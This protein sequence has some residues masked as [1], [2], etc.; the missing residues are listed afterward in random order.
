VEDLSTKTVMDNTE[1]TIFEKLQ[2]KEN[3]DKYAAGL[4]S[5]NLRI[6]AG[7]IGK[8]VSPEL[9]EEIDEVSKDVS[10][11]IWA[12]DRG[13]GPVYDRKITF[14]GIKMVLFAAYNYANLSNPSSSRFSYPFFGDFLREI[15]GRDEIEEAIIKLCFNKP[16]IPN[17]DVKSFSLELIGFDLSSLRVL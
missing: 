10:D 14:G 15:E 2:K 7:N 11:V 17:Y 8:E 16:D 9:E 13:P 1:Y 12:I 4:I 5:R 6:Y 3:W